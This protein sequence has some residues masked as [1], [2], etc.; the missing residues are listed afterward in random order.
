MISS[1]SW[2]LPPDPGSSCSLHERAP[3]PESELWSTPCPAQANFTLSQLHFNSSRFIVAKCWSWCKRAS[4]STEHQHKSETVQYPLKS[5][6]PGLPAAPE[7]WLCALWSF[8]FHRGQW[9]PQSQAG[10]DQQPASAGSAFK[11]PAQWENVPLINNEAIK[12]EKSDDRP[13]SHVQG[14]RLPGGVVHHCR[15]ALEEKIHLTCLSY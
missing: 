6:G 12:S 13:V 3:S 11:S 5:T 9:C 8:H 10:R 15:V 4:K 2:H 1:Y 7:S 14:Q